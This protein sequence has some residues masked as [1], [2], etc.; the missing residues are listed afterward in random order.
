LS[1]RKHERFIKRLETEFSADG[2]DYRGISSDLSLTGLFIRTNHAFSPGTVVDIL[3]HL[4]T[5]SSAKLKGRVRRA[6]KTHVISLKNGMGIELLEKDDIYI[7]FLDAFLAGRDEATRESAAGTEKHATGE[8]SPN[9][10]P[11]EYVIAACS[12]CNVKNRINRSKLALGP[13]CGKCGRPLN[14]LIHKI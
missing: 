4:P 13:K 5:G 9:Q 6:L 7:T 10:A 11:P 12:N 3:L 8:G 14:P 1:K 2:K